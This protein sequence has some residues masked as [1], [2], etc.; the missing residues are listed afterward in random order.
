MSKLV[1]LLYSLARGLNDLEKLASGNPK[2]IARR[3]KNKILGRV[4]S[5]KLYGG[6]GRKKGK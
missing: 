3:G 6:G 1:S 4:V 5:P 2:K